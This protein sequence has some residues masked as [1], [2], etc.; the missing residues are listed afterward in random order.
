M[1][2]PASD[3]P[4]LS[5]ERPSFIEAAERVRERLGVDSLGIGNEELA[6]L[7]DDASG[8]EVSS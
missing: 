6:G 2:V 5:G 7:R 1:I 4:A 8:R 3:H